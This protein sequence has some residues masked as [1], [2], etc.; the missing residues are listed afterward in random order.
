MKESKD[1]S[2]EVW[3]EYLHVPELL[4][5]IKAMMFS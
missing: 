3:G 4:Y 2:T 5:I 1:K